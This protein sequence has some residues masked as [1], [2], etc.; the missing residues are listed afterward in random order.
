[1]KRTGITIPGYRMDKTGKLVKSTKGMS[2]SRVIAQK[3]SKK[4]RVAKR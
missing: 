1:M 3:K 4:V 2:V